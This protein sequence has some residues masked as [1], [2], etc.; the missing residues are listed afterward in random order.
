MRSDTY[1]RQL[2]KVQYDLGTSTSK[3]N[4]KLFRISLG[5]HLECQGVYRK[6]DNKVK[7]ETD[8]IL[9]TK[10]RTNSLQG[11]YLL[12]LLDNTK[13]TGRG[14]NDQITIHLHGPSSIVDGCVARPPGD[15]TRN[16]PIPRKNPT[17]S[18]TYNVHR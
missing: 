4:K 13:L 14:I 6:T 17:F 9:S 7:Y 11:P 2:N 15:R 8:I 16:R 10:A 12:P 18:L 5:E 3:I 1:F